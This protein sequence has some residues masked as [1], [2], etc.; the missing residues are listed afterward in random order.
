MYIQKKDLIHQ[1]NEPYYNN[2]RE[3]IY[4]LQIQF[5]VLVV[6]VLASIRGVFKLSGRKL[7]VKDDCLK[8]SEMVLDAACT[9]CVLIPTMSVPIDPIASRPLAR[10]LL[11][12]TPF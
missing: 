1:H 5:P 7:L 12:T 9:G 8:G 4:K 10:G 6:T 11:L 3:P 2:I